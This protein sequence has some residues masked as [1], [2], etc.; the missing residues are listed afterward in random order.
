MAT[1]RPLRTSMY[2][3]G[4][5]EDW[6][7]KA[8]KYGSD[9][10]ILDLED[11]VPVPNKAEARGLVRKMLEELGGEKPTL[12]VRVNRLETGL[13]SGDLEAVTCPQ[14]YCVLLPKV[15]SPADVVEVDNLLSHFERKVGMEVG[16]IYIDPGM[17]TATSIRLS[18]EIASASPRVA[19][20]GG[21]GGKGG[22]TARSIGFEWTPEGL[23]TL[24]L[25]SKVLIDVRSA[26]VPYPMSGGWMDI[27]NLDGL[28]NLAIQLKQLGYT[29]MHLIHP[30]HVPVVNEVFSPSPEDVK[31]Y[32]GLIAA[33]EDM[34][35]TGAA[36]VTFDGDMVDIAHEETA[37]KM[38]A[39]A[40][41][42]GVEG[43]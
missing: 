31:H 39:I 7:R 40:K 43:A 14:L 42:M 36:A 20:M 30:S 35:A 41:E 11:S 21:S 2:V 25:K 34:R 15:E 26:G 12:T 37:R 38:L 32:K 6:M 5:K 27:H 4:N 9:A 1:P 16:S 13:T 19:H 18:F 28:R 22:D 33:M 23:E 17:E 8:P 24:Y 29:G 3:P 10:L